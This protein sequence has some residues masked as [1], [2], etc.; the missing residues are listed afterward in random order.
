VGV[1][2]NVVN[3]KFIVREGGLE[4]LDLPVHVEKHNRAARRL[5]E[6]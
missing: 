4:T 3:G 5:L 6:G 2:Y 1:D